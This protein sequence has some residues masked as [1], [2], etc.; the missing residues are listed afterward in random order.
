[1]DLDD[2]H[3]RKREAWVFDVDGTLIDSLSGQVLRPHAAEFLGHLAQLGLAIVLWSAGGADY[4]RR[5]AELHG[6]GAFVSSYH[7]KSRDCVD[8][9]WDIAELLGRYDVVRFV[10]DEPGPIPSPSGHEYVV[11]A[12]RPYL[13]GSAHDRA[14]HD[15]AARLGD[16][17]PRSSAHTLQP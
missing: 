10:D 2:E 7:D 12:I 6:I 3:T 16:H 13:G 15:L 17:D 9:C 14:L 5:R 11:E 8:D 4:A 1:M